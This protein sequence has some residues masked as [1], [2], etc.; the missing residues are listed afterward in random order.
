MC[1]WLQAEAA[2]AKGTPVIDIRPSNEF[3]R[4][5]FFC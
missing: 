4:G 5:T 3:E 1:A 2:A